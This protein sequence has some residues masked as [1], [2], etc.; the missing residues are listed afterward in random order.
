MNFL[1]LY[2]TLVENNVQVRGRERRRYLLLKLSPAK[3]EIGGGLGKNADGYECRE[4]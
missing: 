4:W 1:C 2:I 3:M